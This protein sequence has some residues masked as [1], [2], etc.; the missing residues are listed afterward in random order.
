MGDRINDAVQSERIKHNAE[1]R[2]VR[3]VMMKILVK[4]IILMKMEMKKNNDKV[5]VLLLIKQE[6][7]CRKQKDEEQDEY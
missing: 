3:E 1:L 4:E 5:R 2:N 6:Q 7:K